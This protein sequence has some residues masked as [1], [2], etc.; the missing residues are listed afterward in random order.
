MRPKLIPFATL[1]P[2]DKIG[3]LTLAL[4]TAAKYCNV[5]KYLDPSD[6]SKLDDIGIIVYLYD[7]YY[8]IALLAKQDA[9]ARR[10]GKLVTITQRHDKMKAEYNQRSQTLVS[11]IDAKIAELDDHSYD[12]TLDGIK[13]K[14]ASFYEY[15][16]TQKSS[17]LTEHMDIEA[18]F[19]DLALRLENNKRP[20]YSPP[21]GLAPADLIAKLAALETSENN[22]SEALLK[23]LARQNRLDKLSKRFA[24]D[25][26]KFSEWLAEK[27]KYLQAKEQVDSIAQAQLHLNVLASY[28]KEFENVKATRLASLKALV[29]DI[30]GDDYHKKAEI[31][32]K[33]S[34]LEAQFNGLIPHEEAKLQTLEADLARE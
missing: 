22:R 34:A 27:A 7:W 6:I 5:E 18:L 26:A 10:I 2:E 17:Q 11:W 32:S 13:A 12:N 24:S 33:F 28:H 15:K 9:G 14:L 21:A 1:T 20:P 29:D 23:Q 4:D 19:N 3:N 30:V 31:S 16:S 25:A 8:G